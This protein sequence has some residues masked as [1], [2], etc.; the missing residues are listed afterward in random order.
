MIG[1]VYIAL[2][3]D[4][5]QQK[6]YVQSALK[7]VSN[8]RVLSGRDIEKAYPFFRAHQNELAEL[9]H[10]VSTGGIKSV[11]SIRGAQLLR[12]ISSNK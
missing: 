10:L 11:L 2:N 4:N 12:S 1:K 5:E 7:E 6:E 9:F 8:M 3:F